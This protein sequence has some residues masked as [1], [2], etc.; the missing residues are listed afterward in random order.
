MKEKYNIFDKIKKFLEMKLSWI[1]K[2]Y[3]SKAKVSSSGDVYIKSKDIFKGNKKEAVKTLKEVANLT[4]FKL[5]D[6]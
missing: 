3:K 1:V 5:K 2:A 6:A 4:G